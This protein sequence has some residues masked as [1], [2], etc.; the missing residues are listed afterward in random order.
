MTSVRHI[1]FKPL[2]E[3]V[4]DVIMQPIEGIQ[5]LMQNSS[6]D[7]KFKKMLLM[8]KCNPKYKNR[9][10]LRETIKKTVTKD[11]SLD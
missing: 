5:L 8:A 11:E 6:E 1:E 2:P 9:K 4:V 7:V 10:V 3:E